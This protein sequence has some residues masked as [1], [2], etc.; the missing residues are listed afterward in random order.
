MLQYY[1]MFQCREIHMFKFIDV[2]LF[3]FIDVL[4]ASIASSIKL[5]KTCCPAFYMQWLCFLL[6]SR[7]LLE[8]HARSG[9]TC[10]AD[11][12][13]HRLRGLNNQLKT[14]WR[15]RLRHQKLVHVDQN[16]ALSYDSTAAYDPKCVAS[17]IRCGSNHAA[18]FAFPVGEKKREDVQNRLLLEH[19][20][21]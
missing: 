2:L 6:L 10:N 17:A 1:E 4:G 12:W 14:Y 21:F 3:K 19:C 7:D 9:P 11:V 15:F 13:N 8:L 5:L 16:H 20:A 18:W